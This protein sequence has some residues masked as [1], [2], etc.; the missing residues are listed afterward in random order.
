MS[1]KNNRTGFWNML[2][3]LEGDKVIWTIVFLLMMISILAISS[4]TSLMAIAKGTSRLTYIS[5]QVG[6]CIIGMGVIIGCYYIGKIGI[7]WI[8]SRYGFL[9]SFLM[10]AFVACHITFIPGIKAST[11]N[12]TWRCISVF[13]LQLHVF[14]FAKIF[15]V[16]YISWAME[17]IRTGQTTMADELGKLKHLEYLK[18]KNGKYLFYVI[19]PIIIISSLILPGS[20]TS[21]IF[22]GGILFITALIGGLPMKHVLALGTACIIGFAAIFGLYKATGWPERMG[23]FESRLQDKNWLEQLGQL[24][25]GTLEFQKILDESKQP[26]S[27]KIAVSEGGW[28][29]K[30]PGQSTQRYVTA[31]MYED[32]MFSF[33]V[34]EYGIAGA[35]VILLIYGSLLSRG[36]TIVRNCDNRY[37]RTMIAGLVI[38]ISLQAMLHICVNVDI[39]PLTGQTL[40]MISHGKS[41]FIAFC[42]AFGVILSISKMAKKKMDRQAAAAEPIF[43]SG[44]E[45]E[46]N[47][48]EKQENDEQ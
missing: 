16:M 1:Q 20:N 7:F 42:L 48:S 30:G 38:L 27:A 26:I 47:N 29:G 8:F 15:M 17:A 18:T 36:S 12:H 23:T 25:P 4:S 39:G 21:A 46:T 41:S 33:I 31:V 34:E 28:L 13:G 35:I 19:L 43:V 2:D 32:Y 24:K 14:E 22:T 6:L 40:P 11:I 10:T 44:K 37:A 3:N 45:T 5:G 9:L